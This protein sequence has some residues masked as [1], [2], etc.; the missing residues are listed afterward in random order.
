MTAAATTAK[1]R[2]AQGDD[3]DPGLAQKRVCMGVAVVGHDHTG[4]EGD[5]IIAVIPLLTRL[6]I[7]VAP[8]GG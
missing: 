3:L 4:F 8:C 6:F 7:A 2:S 5:D 1:F